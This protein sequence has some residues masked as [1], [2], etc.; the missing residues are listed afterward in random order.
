MTDDTQ[1]KKLEP[2]TLFP[3]SGKDDP[4]SPPGK[5]PKILPLIPMTI[6]EYKRALKEGRQKRLQRS[7]DTGDS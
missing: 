6:E 4:Q 3:V 2:L 5:R 1:E 7:G